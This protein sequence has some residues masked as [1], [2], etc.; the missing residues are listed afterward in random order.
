[1]DRLELA[2]VLL[3]LSAFTRFA[4]ARGAD[5]RSAG[6]IRASLLAFFALFAVLPGTPS[7]ARSSES[8]LAPF[9]RREW[10][11]FL[12]RLQLP[13]H[14]AY[15]VLI[16]LPS[17]YPI[18]LADANA[19]RDSL[20]RNVLR[21]RSHAMA[22]AMIGHAMVGWQCSTGKGL[23]SKT[24]QKNG[25][26]LKMVLAGWGITPLLSVFNDG[27]LVSLEQNPAGYK[28]QI[29]QGRASILAVEISERSCQAM[30]H[31]L[32]QYI[33]HPEKPARRYGLLL[34]SDGFEGDGCMSF[35]LHVLA[36][37]G[38]FSPIDGAFDRTIRIYDS[39][40]GRRSKAPADVDPYVMAANKK[41]ERRVAW[42]QLRFGSWKAGS[43]HDEIKVK[44]PELVYAA[45][46]ALRRMAGER[47][48]RHQRRAL[49]SDDPLVRRAAA[50]TRAW[51]KK[52]FRVM[53]FVAPDDAFALVLER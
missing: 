15:A 3:M 34:D 6:L 35:A 29:S 33:S 39:M 41:D 8:L 53:R 4:S 10:P 37:A 36:E 31:L 23:I 17:A 11:A 5:A 30:R 2:G 26:A 52:R 47:A 51:A 27:R 9:E 7:I 20:V 14:K 32:V 13:E 46:A 18:F 48:G 1:L 42:L 28:A 49:S 38:V 22:K 50:S 44:D 40:L 19:T 25:Q 21:P 24:G 12:K 43:L 16:H 45:V